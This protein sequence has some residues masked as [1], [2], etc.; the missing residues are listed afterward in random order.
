[1]IY[2]L[3]L[4]LL[5]L[6]TPVQAEEFHLELS[7]TSVLKIDRAS[8]DAMLK[9]YPEAKLR[10]MLVPSWCEEQMQAA[11]RSWEE[12]WRL[13]Y[14]SDGKAVTHVYE[15]DPKKGQAAVDLWNAAKE[16]CW[17]TP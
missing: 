6:V 10:V 11:M 8:F 17:R 14:T 15:R 12:V 9:D 16:N 2:L 5:A 3:F 13:E 7:D 4:A 1:M